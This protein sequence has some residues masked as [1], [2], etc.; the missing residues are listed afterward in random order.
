MIPATALRYKIPF[1][2]YFP[3]FQNP[4]HV[5]THQNL[6]CNMKLNALNCCCVGA[7]NYLVL[8]VEFT[9]MIKIPHST[10]S[11]IATFHNKRL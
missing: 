4:W 2:S 9:A 5:N 11:R 3:S 10:Q 1:M 8:G 6:S 7:I